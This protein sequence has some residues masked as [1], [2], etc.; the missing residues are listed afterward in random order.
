MLDAEDRAR[1]FGLRNGPIDLIKRVRE[2]TGCSIEDASAIPLAD[3]FPEYVRLTG[4]RDSRLI[5]LAHHK[6]EDFGPPCQKCGKPLRTPR[7]KHCAECGA[8]LV[9]GLTGK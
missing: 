2:E 3:A 5:E 4:D 1:L 6:L 7:A 8:W 9:D